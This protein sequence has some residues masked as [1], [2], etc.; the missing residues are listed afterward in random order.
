MKGGWRWKGAVKVDLYL[1]R[2]AEASLVGE[3]GVTEDASRP[4][5][6]EGGRQ[7]EV[8]QRALSGRGVTLGAVVTSPLLRARQTAERLERLGELVVCGEV[9]PGGSRKRLC[10]FLRRLGAGSVA[11]VGHEPDLGELAGWLIGSRNA[12]IGFGKAGAALVR[13]EEGP[14]KGEGELVWL[15]TNEW[16]TGGG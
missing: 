15:V 7:A 5:T 9:A 16:A 3:N 10:R 6:A 2:H 8:L 4:L 11:V 14:R 1:I 12:R 13:F